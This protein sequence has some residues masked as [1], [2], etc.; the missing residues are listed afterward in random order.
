MINFVLLLAFI[1]IYYLVPKSVQNLTV[2]I[3]NMVFC[4]I[5]GGF[6]MI[7]FLLLASILAYVGARFYKKNWHFI[8][9]IGFIVILSFLFVFKYVDFFLGIGQGIQILFSG[10]SSIKLLQLMAPVGISFYTLTIL[11]YLLEVKYGLVE[12][13]TNLIKFLCFSTYFP[14]LLSGP[15]SRYKELG[16]QFDVPRELYEQ[17]VY[18]GFKRI[19]WG[20]F[21][22]KVIADRI[23]I[24]VAEIFGNYQNYQGIT[25]IYGAV[26]FAIQ[27]YADFSGYTDIVLGISQALGITLSEN[28][29]APFMARSV[30]EY[31]R[32]WH[33]TL[34]AW[35][36]DY[37]YYPFL[38]SRFIKN[39]SKKTKRKFGKKFSKNLSLILAMLV[40]WVSVGFWHGGA[41][42]Y[43]IGSGLLHGFFI[44]FSELTKDYWAMLYKKIG[45]NTENPVYIW[46]QRIRTF[47]LICIGFVFFRSVDVPSSLDYLKRMIMIN[48]FSMISD[49]SLFMIGT[50]MAGLIIF[51]LAL[52]MLIVSDNLTYRYDDPRVWLNNKSVIFRYAFYW[53]LV[54]MIVLSL[55]LSTEEFLYMQF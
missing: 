7:V 8:F 13:E 51:A 29:K 14:Q 9:V 36:K 20:Y 52:I 11:S 53:A 5:M 26:C 21:K 4:Y 28:F 33:I 35:V 19:L 31:W 22:K 10:S 25:L 45:F 47:V 41:W 46:F 30:A 42:K 44:C 54:V 3:G 37:I 2:F 6:R 40:T 17:N 48:D 38:R 15:F 18:D 12:P 27:L 1:V 23:S 32:R 24:V 50:N 39:I 49:G 55:N 43:I 34:G 16:T